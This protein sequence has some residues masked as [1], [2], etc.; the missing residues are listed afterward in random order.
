MTSS[1]V[2]RDGGDLCQQ[3]PSS[4]QFLACPAAK[5]CVLLPQRVFLRT[6]VILN[7]S[8]LGKPVGTLLAFQ[9]LQFLR[10]CYLP[11]R[12]QGVPVNQGILSLSP[13]SDAFRSKELGSRCMYES[14]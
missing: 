6:Q 12:F 5:D 10:A 4:G 13:D 14:Y 7:R 8:C 2:L 9:V 3:T 1:I 11:L